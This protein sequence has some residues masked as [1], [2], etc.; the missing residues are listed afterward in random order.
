MFAFQF[1]NDKN[2]QNTNLAELPSAVNRKCQLSNL[3]KI[4]LSFWDILHDSRAK[5]YLLIQ[6][7]WA[8]V[9]HEVFC[10]A[11]KTEGLFSLQLINVMLNDQTVGQLLMP[12]GLND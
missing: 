7:I 2:D 11:L 12:V 1:L 10:T 3:E 9:I 8:F 5:I 6:K 4:T